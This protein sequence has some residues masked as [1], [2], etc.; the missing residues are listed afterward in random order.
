MT[1]KRNK[2]QTT[3][4]KLLLKK[5]IKVGAHTFLLLQWMF[6]IRLFFYKL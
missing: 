5:E 1:A 2:I 4:V 3:K 6:H